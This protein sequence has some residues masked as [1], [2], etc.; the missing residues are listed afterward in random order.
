MLLERASGLSAKIAQY[1]QLKGTA[2]E[3]AQFKT[4]ADQFS[5]VAAKLAAV[6]T[7]CARF[8]E[9]GIPVQFTPAE[10]A[11]LAERA[12]TLRSAVEADPHVLGE[13]PFD[14]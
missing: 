12:R 9:A 13:P 7:G 4:R 8:A 11:A 3:A 1:D 10:G 6:R 5:N 14:L 2:E